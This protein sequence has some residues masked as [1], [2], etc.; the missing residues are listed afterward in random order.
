MMCA[1]QGRGKPG[2]TGWTLKALMGLGTQKVP[3][4]M[5]LIIAHGG[6]SS[7]GLYTS[8]TG[9]AGAPCSGRTR[10]GHPASPKA[11]VCVDK[12]LCGI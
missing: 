3:L 11:A 4:C 6:S 10:P 12:H 7:P 9:A 2:W 1:G 8:R 5:K